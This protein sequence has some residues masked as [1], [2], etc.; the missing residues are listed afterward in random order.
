VAPP[1]NISDITA[2]LDQQRRTCAPP[3][4]G[5]ADANPPGA[6][7]RSANSISTVAKPVPPSAAAGSIDDCEK[8]IS[9]GGL[10]ESGQPLPAVP[11]DQYRCSGIQEVHRGRATD[12]PEFGETSATRDG[13]S[14]STCGSPSPISTWAI[15]SNRDSSEEPGAAAG[16]RGDVAIT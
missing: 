9:Y 12:G 15:S 4:A 1:R 5:E 2:I 3:G 7:A 14:A 6:P 11:V 8:A 10:R 13:F 16:I